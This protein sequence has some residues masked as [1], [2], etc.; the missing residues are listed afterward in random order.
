MTTSPT[1]PSPTSSLPGVVTIAQGNW[2]V[3][4]MVTESAGVKIFLV[5]FRGRR[6]LWE[7]TLPYVTIHN[8]RR[9]DHKPCWLCTGKRDVRGQ[10]DR[11]R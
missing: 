2:R 3:H 9:N 4:Y 10:A 8:H 6:V 11:A 1:S 5:D 7:A